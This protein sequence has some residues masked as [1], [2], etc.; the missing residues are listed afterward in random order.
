[1]N[2][3]L[4]FLRKVFEVHSTSK[5]LH[6]QQEYIER[7][8]R[9]D[10]CEYLTECIENCNVIDATSIMDER[11]HYIKGFGDDCKKGGFLDE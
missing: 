1:M 5:E 6:K 4:N 9:C 2:R 10:R 8:T 7:D 3:F 11:K